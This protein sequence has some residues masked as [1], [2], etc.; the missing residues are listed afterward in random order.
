MSVSPSTYPSLSNDFNIT[1]IHIHHLHVKYHRHGSCDLFPGCSVSYQ[2]CCDKSNL[3][4][5]CLLLISTSVISN[6]F[7][8]A[9]SPG[10]LDWIIVGSLVCC[11][12]TNQSPTKARCQ[13]ERGNWAYVFLILT[14]CLNYF[15]YFK[16]EL[17]LRGCRSVWHEGYRL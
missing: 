13:C 8:L 5:P 12:L 15:L 16:P 11:M 1:L 6:S 3:M 7:K 4:R 2:M 14:Y 9:H 17:N 10:T